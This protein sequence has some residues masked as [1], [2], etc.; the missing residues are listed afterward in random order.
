M[1]SAN[2][3]RP[4]I[5]RAAVPRMGVVET[6]NRQRDMNASRPTKSVLTDA[7][8]PSARVSQSRPERRQQ[9]RARV[10]L[11]VR[12]RPADL[13]CGDFDQVLATLNSCR[14][15]LY[16]K[17]VREHFYEGQR[18]RIVFPYNSAHDSVS[19]SEAYGVV[20][21]LDRLPDGQLGVA[22]RMGE[23]AHRNAGERRDT[24]RRPFSAAAVMVEKHSGTRLQA[25]CSDL[26]ITGCYVDTINPLPEKARV[27]LRLSSGQDT[28]ET[29][30][31]VCFSH[32]GMGMGLAFND[33]A[34]KQ[35]SI[36]VKWL[37]GGAVEPIR[38]AQ[39]PAISE[40]A[41]SPD[42]AL[43]LRLIRLLRSKNILMDADV[44]ALLSDRVSDEEATCRPCLDRL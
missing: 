27:Q 10:G 41:P 32:T 15:G 26:S 20:V 4:A 35:K 8:D 5:A 31:Q 42:R 40:S 16:F 22:V 3:N 34:P 6:A 9:R 1:S 17:T 38:V 37:N 13:N 24:A 44:L 28:F 2:Q 12:L 7:G 19:A 14:N 30:A 43:A 25:R 29:A 33:V 11:P 39:Q 23:L 21:R 36:L 18:L